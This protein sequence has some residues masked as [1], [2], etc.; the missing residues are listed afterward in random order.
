MNQRKIGKLQV[1]FYLSSVAL[2]DAASYSTMSEFVITEF[3]RLE[4]NEKR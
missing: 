1:P 2:S 3:T 4:M